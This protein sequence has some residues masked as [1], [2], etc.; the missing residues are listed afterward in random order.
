MQFTIPRDTI[1]PVLGG[2]SRTA[3]PNGP[4]PQLGFAQVT[5]TEG[6]LR[7]FATNLKWSVTHELPCAG[8]TQPGQGAI[9]AKLV[10]DFVGQLPP[11][12]IACTW[13]PDTLR[14]DLACRGFQ[15]QLPGW[16]PEELPAPPGAG[17]TP[18]TTLPA[19][20]LRTLLESVGYAAADDATKVLSNVLFHFHDHQLTL[21]GAD[22]FRLVRRS[23]PLE[24]LTL[25]AGRDREDLQLLVP[26]AVAAEL[27][28]GLPEAKG[29][30]EVLVTLA[31]TPDQHHLVVQAPGWTFAAR[32]ADGPYVDYTGFVATHQ[33]GPTQVR[34]LTA[35]LLKALRIAESFAADTHHSVQLELLPAA[36]PTDPGQVRVGAASERGSTLA[37]VD[38]VIAGEPLTVAFNTKLLR[39][40]LANLG[41]PHP[42]LRL[43][44]PKTPAIV[45]PPETAGTDHLCLL[46][47]LALASRTGAPQAPPPAP[48]PVPAEAASVA[49][50][51][52]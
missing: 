12:A 5:A 16:N 17:A 23:T 41:H 9:P 15:A 39:E 22:G 50:A 14:L 45:A 47:P 32:L 1:L 43:R 31:L 44:T 2:L 49:A 52:A 46:M 42:V 34:L 35:E 51:V 26:A 21:V 6:R 4:L 48:H 38:A 7:L 13:H 19:P 29:S 18:L 27:A 10:T 36:D 30:Q 20:T 3:R 24:T 25:P 40:A 11:E 33:A 37:L 8:I 28:A